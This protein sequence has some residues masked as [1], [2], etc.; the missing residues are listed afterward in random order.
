[1]PIVYGVVAPAVCFHTTPLCPRIVERDWQTMSKPVRYENAHEAVN[2]GHLRPCNVC[3][4]ALAVND[5]E[6]MIRLTVEQ[7]D[8]LRVIQKIYDATKSPM[9]LSQIAAERKREIS[10]CFKIVNAL[11]EKG[12]IVKRRQGRPLKNSGSIVPS[13]RVSKILAAVPA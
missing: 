10:T 8:T 1:M 7:I 3:A 12:L 4:V 9:T 2:A 11:V 5:G 13:T 6:G